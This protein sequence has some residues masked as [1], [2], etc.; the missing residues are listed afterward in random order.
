MQKALLVYNP[1]S[2]KSQL[3][4]QASLLNRLSTKGIQT[5]SFQLSEPT[6][7]GALVDILSRD[8]FDLAAISGGD[9]TINFV[10]NLLLKNDFNIPVGI[11]PA[12]TSNDLARN[13]KVPLNQGKAVEL[14]TLGVTRAIDVGLINESTYF[15]SSCSGGLFSDISYKTEGALKKRFG[16]LAYYFRGVEELSRISPFTLSVKTQS[17]AFEEDIL[18]FFILNGPNVAGLSNLVKE[19]EPTDGLLHLV[20]IKKSAIGDLIDIFVKIIKQLP[21]HDSDKVRIVS[22]PEFQLESELEVPLSVDGEKNGTLPVKLRVVP[23]RLTVFTTM[24]LY[25]A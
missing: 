5:L 24:G 4:Q 2:G 9:G 10:V 16:P 18:L 15:M 12:G 17:A 7:A 19:A 8:P 6:D 11:I 23:K 3:Q 1:R 22:A 14:M 21:L 13:L 25:P 20:L